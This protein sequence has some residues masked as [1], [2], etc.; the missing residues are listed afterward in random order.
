[1]SLQLALTP[2]FE[3]LRKAEGTS[4]DT[5]VPL[6]P[7]ILEIPQSNGSA[8]YIDR[9]T[10][11]E[12]GDYSPPSTVVVRALSSFMKFSGPSDE[13]AQPDQS[14][15]SDMLYKVVRRSGT[16][17]E[18]QPVRRNGGGGG[19]SPFDAHRQ[20]LS[21]YLR[22]RL[23]S[24]ASNPGRAAEMQA[25]M[26]R[27]LGDTGRH[28]R[29]PSDLSWI[30][31]DPEMQAQHPGLLLVSSQVGGR[32]ND[33]QLG[34]AVEIGLTYA[35]ASSHSPSDGSSSE[36]D[37]AAM[38]AMM[39]GGGGSS[40]GSV[41]V[42]WTG[43]PDQ[44]TGATIRLKRD[45]RAWTGG[46]VRSF[47]GR[48]RK[49]CV[50][51]DSGKVIYVDFREETF[52]VTKLST[53]MQEQKDIQVALMLERVLTVP[54]EPIVAG[55]IANSR[56]P[57][58]LSGVLDARTLPRLHKVLN[59]VCDSMLSD[60]TLGPHQT[61]SLLAIV[62]V[63][64]TA[65]LQRYWNHVHQAAKPSPKDSVQRLG[66]EFE[67][68]L[69]QINEDRNKALRCFWKCLDSE[70]VRRDSAYNIACVCSRDREAQAA[71]RWFKHAVT[72]GYA[73]V[74]HARSDEDFDNV[75]GDPEFERL[76]L[77]MQ[78]L[79]F[80][81]IVDDGLAYACFASSEHNAFVASRLPNTGTSKLTRTS[82][83]RL[84]A[85]LRQFVR[86]HGNVAL[87]TSN[88]ARV[89][90]TTSL[91]ASL[92]LA[93][94]VGDQ[95][96]V[97]LVLEASTFN[98]SVFLD[99]LRSF[100]VSHA[101][102]RNS[103][104]ENVDM[105]HVQTG[106]MLLPSKEL[107]ASLKP[108]IL[109]PETV[110]DPSVS[111][112]LRFMWPSELSCTFSSAVDLMELSGAYVGCMAK[113]I[114]ASVVAHR[115]VEP[116]APVLRHVR[117]LIARV[118]DIAQPLTSLFVL[119]C[120]S[121]PVASNAGSTSCVD[122]VF[123][124]MRHL[125]DEL[126]EV[127]TSLTDEEH[128]SLSGS[129][130]TLAVL[131]DELLLRLAEGFTIW[132]EDRELR[133]EQDGLQMAV[134][135]QAL[136][137]Q[138]VAMVS[139]G[140]GYLSGSV[141]S[142]ASLVGAGS[143]ID[144][145]LEES[146]AAYAPKVIMRARDAAM[147]QEARRMIAK[148]FLEA[149]S[150][151]GDGSF[152][153]SGWNEKDVW[154]FAHQ[155]AQHA[156]NAEFAHTQL[157]TLI[158]D[159]IGRRADMRS[160]V[161]AVVQQ[162]SSSDVSRIC[163][164][165]PV[166][167][168][169][170]VPPQD[171]QGLTAC[172]DS[173]VRC[174][175]AGQFVL[176]PRSPMDALHQRCAFLKR[177]MEQT[178]HATLPQTSVQVMRDFLQASWV[179]DS[180]VQSCF[181]ADVQ[182][183]ET[184]VAQLHWM[185][186]FLATQDVSQ[187]QSSLILSTYDV[188]RQVGRLIAGDSSGSFEDDS[189]AVFP[190][191]GTAIRLIDAR[192]KVLAPLLNASATEIKPAKRD[193]EQMPASRR[194]V[195]I[196]SLLVAGAPDLAVFGHRATLERVA[197]AYG[198][199]VCA[200][201]KTAEIEGG[202]TS[203]SSL[204][205]TEAIQHP[206]TNCLLLDAS[207]AVV[208]V[209]ECDT[210]FEVFMHVIQHAIRQAELGQPDAAA[211]S[212]AS[213][214]KDASASED[215]SL[216][217]AVVS[218]MLQALAS[219]WMACS[220]K[221]GQVRAEWWNDLA[222]CTLLSSP[223]PAVGHAGKAAEF[224][225]VWLFE[226][227][228][229]DGLRVLA[230]PVL[231]AAL[232]NSRP[233][234]QQY[235]LTALRLLDPRYVVLAGTVRE[236]AFHAV[237]FSLEHLDVGS[238]DGSDQ[239][240]AAL[241][242]TV[243]QNPAWSTPPQPRSASV[244]IMSYAWR[245]ELGACYGLIATGPVICSIHELAPALASGCKLDQA[246]AVCAVNLSLSPAN[247][248]VAIDG[249]KAIDISGGDGEVEDTLGAA[250]LES[251]SGPHFRVAKLSSR[252]VM[253]VV[254]D[255]AHGEDE[256]EADDDAD[257][258]ANQAFGAARW[259][260]HVSLACTTAPTS[261]QTPARQNTLASPSHAVMGGRGALGSP[262]SELDLMASEF[263]LDA[264][265]PD[266]SDLAS[267]MFGAGSAQTVPHRNTSSAFSLVVPVPRSDATPDVCGSSTEGVDVYAAAF[268]DSC[269]RALQ[270]AE[271]SGFAASKLLKECVQCMKEERDWHV[272]TGPLHKCLQKSKHF[273]A[274]GVVCYISPIS[275]GASAGRNKQIELSPQV[276]HNSGHI[277]HSSISSLASR[278]MRAQLQADTHQ[279]SSAAARPATS[280]AT[281]V[282]EAVYGRLSE[283]ESGIS[284]MT[285]SARTQLLG[286]I[287]V[288]S[289]SLL[290]LDRGSWIV[291][292]PSPNSVFSLAGDMQHLTAKLE[293]AF[294]YEQSVACREADS[295][296][297][298][299]FGDDS[300]DDSAAFEVPFSSILTD[301]TEFPPT[302]GHIPPRQVASVLL[303]ALETVEAAQTKS[304]MNAGDSL[305][306][307]VAT[308]A[309]AA[310]LQLSS[311]PRWAEAVR[312]VVAGIERTCPRLLALSEAAGTRAPNVWPHIHAGL[313]LLH[314]V[315]SGSNDA[316][317]QGVNTSTPTES[318]GPTSIDKNSAWHSVVVEPVPLDSSV[319][320]TPNMLAAACPSV[321]FLGFMKW[322]LDQRR[323]VGSA[324]PYRISEDIVFVG[325][326]PIPMAADAF[327]FEAIVESAERSS[328]NRP[329]VKVGLWAD[330][331][332]TR[333][334]G[335]DNVGCE[336]G[337]GSVYFSSSDGCKGEWSTEVDQ[338]PAVVAGDRVIPVGF[339]LDVEDR[340]G[341]VTWRPAVT[342]GT[343][344]NGVE[345]HIHYLV[346]CSHINAHSYTHTLTPT[347]CMPASHDTASDVKPH[348]LLTGCRQT[349]LDVE[350]GRVDSAVQQPPG[351]AGKAHP[352]Q[353][354]RWIHAAFFIQS[355][356][357]RVRGRRHW[358]SV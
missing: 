79:T 252:V 129:K 191:L 344:N 328:N 1:M 324:K 92:A 250:L 25:M 262:G 342:I 287:Q 264:T 347:H 268:Q 339:P 116:N 296:T 102:A 232:A 258:A 179:D 164:G 32:G 292:R 172:L 104:P 140:Y 290:M 162:L 69:E 317:L 311:S 305:A 114:A 50:R 330:S 78:R 3:S 231:R 278:W 135:Q 304:T 45:G 241:L 277:T 113:R 294:S 12:K 6:P 161:D 234:L 265:A 216:A 137:P 313:R 184:A 222:S 282:S 167:G 65:V 281:A 223:S 17:F 18:V 270:A 55:Y 263:M 54:P 267:A 22:E 192:Y 4:L 193:V 7:H 352:R 332:L 286:A 138:L 72:C 117:R 115:P 181:G 44:L 160:E 298:R 182:L 175:D 70:R 150:A 251:D 139:T 300:V 90:L 35:A 220:S 85:G 40:S 260:V 306:V 126:T 52:E 141:R 143:S 64:L 101:Q 86:T 336:W 211:L 34:C 242:W 204:V 198:R 119:L 285:M 156:L 53:D 127:T 39:A 154:K 146:E 214:P 106:M 195:L 51:L 322:D 237:T 108:L 134:S 293:D 244:H 248:E 210:Q 171:R 346:R 147:V 5:L 168:L 308:G 321:Q 224:L 180:A 289:N 57:A 228:I 303:Q 76:L 38:L 142:R 190:S 348:S 205:S 48:R 155:T 19:S 123:A 187:L 131:R 284:E 109:Q 166:N 283:A 118:M 341:T 329:W 30:K 136:Y 144:A 334:T 196:Q 122:R 145:R 239:V 273:G 291:C 312:D 316:L 259:H 256:D 246:Y 151:T 275:G 20:E 31:V 266:S 178:D 355:R 356:S 185:S 41:T 194:L 215:G 29:A 295:N 163:T 46:T 257:S 199:S 112:L 358:L 261:P 33:G 16:F 343:R 105:R 340:N 77:A 253:L 186:S 81:P 200:S 84:F 68:G 100:F 153:V 42:P 120:S 280:W 88:D 331:P 272:F 225:P 338:W 221:F 66:N 111:S 314:Q 326:K 243:G 203:S 61:G 247:V 315:F 133:V 9:I 99:V 350:V 183:E 149:Q 2:G 349:G 15:N 276:A 206:V 320:A 67:L 73:N 255:K 37:T 333:G 124:M 96:G 353:S 235:A 202:A 288:I 325:N 43:Q 318:D 8:K 10:G 357:D 87:E 169:G 335:V 23:S 254:P 274:V 345:V 170:V 82:Y 233:L 21:E 249:F 11:T 47:D 238:I 299:L 351:H 337:A 95:H 28:T 269:K 132:M 208:Q 327:Y 279:D 301:V 302:V 309:L 58:F 148:P 158:T 59:T 36:D 236:E 62:S 110:T 71:V 271:S 240:V 121:N 227:H 230:H 173:F 152:I 159:L 80:V 98:R 56:L 26:S 97:G 307:A 319:E 310:L 176:F 354:P 174:S 27:L 157:A 323:G 177:F 201:W 91:Q 89:W 74:A 219:L 245:P 83:Y 107:V 24:A 207:S 165:W 218:Y 125:A 226:R 93:C 75:R 103:Q 297:R 197:D 130:R 94:R 14:I 212:A 229:L 209:V 63:H 128:V 213:L 13:K 189:R 188:L 49:H 60:L 217:P